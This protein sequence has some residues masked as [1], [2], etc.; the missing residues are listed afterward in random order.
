MHHNFERKRFKVAPGGRA[1][2]VCE[3]VGHHGEKTLKG[4]CCFCSTPLPDAKL[5]SHP[6][7][8]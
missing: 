5:P 1:A 4:L 8:R 7:Q 2:S 6:D 3:Q